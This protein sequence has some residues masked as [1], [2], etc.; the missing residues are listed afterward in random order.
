MRA[1]TTVT[2]TPE[3]TAIRIVR[4]RIWG[5]VAGISPPNR[6][7]APLIPIASAT[8]NT[9]PNIEPMTLTIRASLNTIPRT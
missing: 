5:V 3:S 4:G 9:T 1:D 7:K 8:P 6:L 2:T